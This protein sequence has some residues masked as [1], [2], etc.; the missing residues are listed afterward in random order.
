MLVAFVAITN[1]APITNPGSTGATGP[2]GPSGSPGPQ[3]SPGPNTIAST[4]AVLKG[5]N[6]GGAVAAT[7][8]TDFARSGYATTVAAEDTTVLTVASAYAQ[9]VTGT[10][11][12]SFEL[13][14]ASTL[15]LGF[16]FLFVNNSTSPID[17]KSS[18]S[19]NVL[20][21][22]AGVTAL[23]TCI[24]TSGTGAVSWSA[25][26]IS[27]YVSNAAYGI[28]WSG[29][30]TIAPSQD[31]VRTQFES[32]AGKGVIGTAVIEGADVDPVTGATYTGIISDVTRPHGVSAEYIVVFSISQPDTNYAIPAPGF[33]GLNDNL[34]C[35]I[36]AKTVDGFRLDFAD[37]VDA[38][39]DVQ[40]LDIIVI[41]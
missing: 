37:D 16:P 18:G 17:V 2:A 1:L 35:R 34:N 8:G 31:Q 13:P 6:A 19:N 10:T 20:T 26:Q 7:E 11:D 23:V 40:K 3:G 25:K 38:P 36:S 28:G 22:P 14:V 30:T 9:F 27:G 32:L 29:V 24:V 39:A 15:Y 21:V 33:D 5:D 4:T 41:R 12:H